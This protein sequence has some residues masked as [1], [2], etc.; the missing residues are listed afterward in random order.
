MALPA[1]PMTGRPCTAVLAVLQARELVLPKPL[2]LN[3]RPY[4]TYN[5]KP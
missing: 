2:A 3:P 1:R 5:N 4:K